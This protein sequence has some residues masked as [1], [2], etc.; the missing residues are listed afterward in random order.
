MKTIAI[1]IVYDGTR[2]SGWQIQNNSPTIQ[3]VIENALLSISGERINI[4]GAG[5][6][7]AGVH[8][9]GQVASFSINDSLS[10]PIEKLCVALNSNLPPDIRIVNSAITKNDFNARFSAIGREYI[11]YLTNC[12]SV[13]SRFYRGFIKYPFDAEL[14]TSSGDLFLGKHDF[15]GFSKYNSSTKNY[16]CNIVHCKWSFGSENLFILKIVADRFVYGMVRSIV[17]SM[18]AFS[19][20]KINENNIKHQLNNAV[21]K[22][23]APLAPP[24]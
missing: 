10:I 3:S 21:R 11:Y 5:R 8:S 22:P 16:F 2:Y 7:D 20:S 19:R 23:F 14:L 12:Y 18:I 1:K 24:E 13:F 6:T 9:F 17:G 15:T 4:V